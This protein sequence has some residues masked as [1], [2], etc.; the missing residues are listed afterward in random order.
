MDPAAY[1]T[2][3]PS[4]L[5][6]PFFLLVLLVPGSV[7][8]CE[9]GLTIRMVW[10]LKLCT[11]LT[12][13]PLGANSLRLSHRL[14]PAVHSACSSP[15]LLLTTN[16]YCIRSGACDKVTPRRLPRARGCWRV[17]HESSH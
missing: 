4:P 10:S 15:V 9:V 8:C 1:F 2:R 12:F 17:T 3:L 6:Y 11:T 16:L 14:G 13:P 7:A 5:F